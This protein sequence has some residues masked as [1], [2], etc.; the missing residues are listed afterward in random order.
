[1]HARAQPSRDIGGTQPLGQLGLVHQ[2][3]VGQVP[4]DTR[5]AVAQQ[6]LAQNAAHAVGGDQGIAFYQLAGPG[7]H[8][9]HAVGLGKALDGLAQVQVHAR[10]SLSGF[11]QQLLQIGP[12]DGG[13]GRAI[14]LHGLA[15]QGHM[16][17]F[18]PGDCAAHAQ[19]A[20]QCHHLLQRFLQAPGLKP[21]H[22]IRTDLD[23]GAHFTERG[24]LLEK[25]HFPTRPRRT[26]GGGQATNAA[27]GNQH[28]LV[29][30]RI[31]PLPPPMAA[32]A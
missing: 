28:L 13:V 2:G 19:A 26:D 1:M 3:A 29:H 30:V 8:G 16:R 7:S 32:G 5:R 11:P 9:D 21:P 27:A 15:A 14:A 22:D 24:R 31:V 6:L 4:G 10:I 18:L 17:Q 20:R 23:S 25:T 12:V